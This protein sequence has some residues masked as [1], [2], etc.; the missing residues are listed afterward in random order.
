M[1]FSR[2]AA[3]ASEETY[4]DKHV[5]PESTSRSS[6]TKPK[7]SSTGQIMLGLSQQNAARLEQNSKTQETPATEPHGKPTAAR[8]QI[9]L[10]TLATILGT[11]PTS[12]PE[13]TRL[14]LFAR[15]FQHV[16]SGGASQATESHAKSTAVPE[17]M[18]PLKLSTV[19]QTPPLSSAAQYMFER[20]Q[21]LSQ[22]NENSPST[23]QA[24][25]ES[26]SP[27]SS[28]PGFGGGP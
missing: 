27:I 4:R 10:P 12:T 23:S 16:F 8:K 2:D 26:M 24:R 13:A 19:L 7:I 11:S 18:Q 25:G 22:A 21:Q 9:P 5:D 14:P 20:S 1:K 28:R 3:I 15:L 6:F 17:Q